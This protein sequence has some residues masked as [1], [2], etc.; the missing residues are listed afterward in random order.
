MEPKKPQ[1]LASPETMGA[2]M[3]ASRNGFSDEKWQ[4]MLDKRKRQP[5][6]TSRLKVLSTVS[7]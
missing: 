3:E 2:I 5:L 7:P 4:E 1:R 6:A